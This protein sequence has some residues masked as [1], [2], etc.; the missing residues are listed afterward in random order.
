MVL[1]HFLSSISSYSAKEE[2]RMDNSATKPAILIL[3]AGEL[4]NEVISAVWDHPQRNDTSLTV[5]LRPDPRGDPDSNPA[6]L[7]R[8]EFISA[9]QRRGISTVRADVANDTEADL[10]AIFCKYSTIIGCTG[11][12]YPSGLVFSEHIFPSIDIDGCSGQVARVACFNSDP[13]ME[14]LTPVCQ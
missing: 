8:R 10:A 9:L 6:T 1:P 12:T 3:G 11:M 13:R 7:A 14:M 2:S 4:G 5:L